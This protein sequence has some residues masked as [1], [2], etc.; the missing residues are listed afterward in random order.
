MFKAIS[1]ATRVQQVSGFPST[2]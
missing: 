1:K 2:F